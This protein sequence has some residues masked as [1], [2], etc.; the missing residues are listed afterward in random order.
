M[1][2]LSIFSNKRIV[3]ERYKQ[4]KEISEN[5]IVIDEYV[6]NGKILKI[7]LMNKYMLDISGEVSSIEISC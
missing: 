2:K 7:K 1:I 6:I 4:V 3:I 5:K